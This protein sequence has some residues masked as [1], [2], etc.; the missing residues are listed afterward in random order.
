[1]EV[2]FLPD[3]ATTRRLTTAELRERFAFDQL[4]IPGQITTVYCDADRSILGFAIPTSG[5]LELTASRKEMAA[6]HFLERRELGIVNVGGAGVVTA[7]GKEFALAKRDMLYLGRGT[8]SVLFRSA[9]G[10]N[11]A[12]FFLVSYPAHR[13]YPARLMT[14][15]ESTATALGSAK[16]AN[17]RTIHKYIHESGIASCQLVMG[18]TVLE[19]G[20]VWN[21]MPPHT[22][23][24]RSEIYMYFDV[25]EDGMVVHLMGEP[26]ETRHVILRNRN[27]VISPVWSIHAGAA[28]QAYSF[29]W[30][31]G[32]ENQAFDDMDKVAVR[33]LK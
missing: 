11:P 15:A 16:D 9:S 19:E 26:S 33:D 29:I 10:S 25:P 17:K 20:C 23:L 31:M 18:L 12:A 32:G 14:F 5:P 21:T 3:P 13:E 28:T 2:R 30:A 1:M 7:D 6:D 27:A 24:R 8:K 4:A 22:H